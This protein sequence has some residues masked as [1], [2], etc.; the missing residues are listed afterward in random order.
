MAGDISVVLRADPAQFE[1]GVQATEAAIDKFIEASESGAEN[2][3]E[4]FADVLRGLIQ[5]GRQ[6]GRT[7]TEMVADLRKL[8]LSAEDAEDAIDAIER[9]TDRL[10]R[11]GTRNLKRADDAVDDLGDTAKKTGDDLDDMGDAATGAADKTSEIGDKADGVGDGLRSLGDIAKDVLSGDFDSAASGALDALGGIATAAGVGGAVGGAVVSALSGLVGALIEQ[12]TAYQEKVDEVRDET[13]AALVE[14]GGAFDATALQSRILDI[15][16]DTDKWNQALLISQ[17]TGLDMGIVLNGLAGE[18]E[19]AATTSQRFAEV[20]EN[21]PGS[22]DTKVMYDAKASL[23]GVTS[24]LEG[25][26]AKIDAVAAANARHTESARE[27]ADA[28]QAVRDGLLTMPQNVRPRIDLDDSAARRK[29]NNLVH[30]ITN[31][32]ATI[33]IGG[34]GSARQI[35]GG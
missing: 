17:Q 7:R 1:R 2:V 35:L 13:Q 4:A 24:A 30:D 33:K 14:M 28:T 18:A 29:L 12:F 19:D 21:I 23:E 32:T 11:D 3:D 5:L 25:A 34:S 27:A 15:V 9:E 10:G 6:S 20:W 26:P 16:N 31:T 8:G 22:V